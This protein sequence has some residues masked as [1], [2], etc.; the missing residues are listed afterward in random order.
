M[1]HKTFTFCCENFRGRT[2]FYLQPRII[3]RNIPIK[4]TRPDRKYTIS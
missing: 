3:L 1:R 2:L 4:N